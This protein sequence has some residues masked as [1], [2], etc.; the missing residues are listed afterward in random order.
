MMKKYLICLPAV[1]LGL[2]MHAQN[3]SKQQIA[4]FTKEGVRVSIPDTLQEFDYHFDYSVFDSP[5][6]GAYEFSPYF[7]QMTPDKSV[8]DGRTFRL[9]GGAG[10][11]LHP[12]L[13]FFWTPIRT[14]KTGLTVYNSG[15]AYFGNYTFDPK[16]AVFAGRDASDKLRFQADFIRPDSYVKIRGGWNG[17]FSKSYSAGSAYNA[18]DFDV[19]VKSRIDSPSFFYYDFDLG[20]KF[21]ADNITTGGSISDHVMSFSG[22]V[23]PVIKKKFRLL[24]DFHADLE[25]MRS[26]Y[27]GFADYNHFIL[28]ATPHIV[29]DAGP[30]HLDAGILVDYSHTNRNLFSLSPSVKASVTILKDVI[31]FYAGFVGGQKMHTYLSLKEF[32][33]FDYAMLPEASQVR[34]DAFGGIRGVI[35]PN[36][37]YDLKVGY[38]VA[39]NA[40][41][42]YYRIQYGDVSKLYINLSFAWRSENFEVDGDYS[43]APK[44][45]LYRGVGFQSPLHLGDVRAVYN[46]NKRIY[47]GASIKTCS[48]RKC[49]DPEFNWVPWYVSPGVMFEYRLSRSLGLWAEGGNL[50][51]HKIYDVPGY[52]MSGPYFTVG[53]SCSL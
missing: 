13:D 42:D 27:A 40:L 29:M 52:A 12:V 24:V 22:C 47:L 44:R 39:D 45:A 9:R 38:M 6:K 8:Y 23:G 41:I 25:A 51:G 49:P 1:L 36:L 14:E 10:Y 3:E 35:G 32:N 28:S 50:L 7:V 11:S 53:V 34:Y 5:Y 15:K 33:H 31:D 30:V 48:A 46:W 16:N 19:D 17:I 43:F 2:A 21:A 26:A 18:L 4:D 20:Y 37:D